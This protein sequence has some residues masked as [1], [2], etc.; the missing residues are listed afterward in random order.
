M[1]DAGSY[2]GWHMI[3]DQSLFQLLNAGSKRG[4][5]MDA[6][7]FSV[8]QHYV[9]FLNREP[10]TSGLNFWTGEIHNCSPKP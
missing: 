3:A 9:D 4:N 6:S 10:E 5:Q 2:L 1:P 7:G 8:R